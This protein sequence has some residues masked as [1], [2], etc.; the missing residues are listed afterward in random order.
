[1]VMGQK[2]FQGGRNEKAQELAAP[3]LVLGG[4]E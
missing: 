1:M 2:V 4:V 3:R